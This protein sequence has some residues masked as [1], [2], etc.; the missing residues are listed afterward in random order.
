[1]KQLQLFNAK[2]CRICGEV[3]SLTEF[4]T[5]HENRDGLSNRC[6]RCL[7]NYNL[8]YRKDNRQRIAERQAKWYC[9]NR[10]WRLR[11][12]S[13]YFQRNRRQR[14]EV[15]REYKRRNPE[16]CRAHLLVY[17]ALK[18]GN[19][20]RRPCEECGNEN[21]EAHHDDYTKPL[22]VIWLCRGCHQRLHARLVS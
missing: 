10:D 18:A 9:E 2:S 6:K 17:R 16:K 8:K 19:S 14:L 21:S 11:H 15:N 3:K 22:E 20:S 5:A 7:A 4:N 1:M 13:E 12:Q